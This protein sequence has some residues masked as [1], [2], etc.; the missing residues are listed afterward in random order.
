MTGTCRTHVCGSASA[1]P[2]FPS[3]ERYGS[4]I[5][6]SPDTKGRGSGA[7]SSGFEG[8]RGTLAARISARGRRMNS[9]ASQRDARA[10]PARFGGWP[11]EG[12][13]RDRSPRPR[14]KSDVPHRVARRRRRS[15]RAA[16]GR[17]PRRGAHAGGRGAPRAGRG[18]GGGGGGG[19]GDVSEA[20]LTSTRSRDVRAAG[21]Q[22]T[23]PGCRAR[24]VHIRATRGGRENREPEPRS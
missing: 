23:S 13:A 21:R 15:H 3:G 8:F 24:T 5:Q 7:I 6:H 16:D 11:G 10:A 20:R 4:A 12:G 2:S 1:R 18:A 14:Q 22:M 19:D 9:G 17:A